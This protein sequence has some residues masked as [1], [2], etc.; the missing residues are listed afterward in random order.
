MEDLLVDDTIGGNFDINWV[1]VSE[2]AATNAAIST[3]GP[4][5]GGCVSAG[6]GVRTSVLN[7]AVDDPF[8]NPGNDEPVTFI[9]ASSAASAF[10]YYVGRIR[11]SCTNQTNNTNIEWGCEADSPPDGGLVT[12]ATSSGITPGFSIGSFADLSA[13]VITSGLN[14]Q[15]AVTGINVAQP[16]GS[17]GLVT[18]TIENLSGATIRNLDLTDTLPRNIQRFPLITAYRAE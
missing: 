2:A 18:I 9:D 10:V 4:V 3:G 13:Q 8:G 11:A 16:V 14:I 15:Q 1:C 5:P 7:F 6:G 17:S 12:P